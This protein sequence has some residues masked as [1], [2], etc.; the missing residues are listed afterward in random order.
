MVLLKEWPPGEE[1]TYNNID[2][3]LT[4]YVFTREMAS[5]EGGHI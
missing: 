1:L 3:V 2:F 5:G 4:N